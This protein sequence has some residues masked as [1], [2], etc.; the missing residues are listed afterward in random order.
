MNFI[1]TLYIHSNKDPFRDPFGWVSPEYHLMSWALSCLQLKQ[2]YKEVYLYANTPAA[3][4]LIDDLQ[5]PY[6]EVFCTHDKLILPHQELWALPKIYTYRLQ[7]KPFLHIDGDVFLFG[8]LP[9]SLLNNGLIAQNPEVATDY[10]T[11]TQKGLMNHFTFFPP[12]VKTDFEAP[13]PIRAVNAGI[14]GGQNISFINEY[15]NL[16]FEYV[17]KNIRYLQSINVNKFNVFFEQHLFYALAKEKNIPIG[18]LFSDLIDDNGYKHINDFHD[19]PFLRMYLHLLGHF[20][21]DEYTCIQMAA[22]LRELYPDYYY[23]IL[24]LFGKKE[25]TLSP[26]CFSKKIEVSVNYQ[27][28]HEKAQQAYND[29]IITIDNTSAAIDETTNTHLIRLKEVANFYSD[30]NEEMKKDFA[31]FYDSLIMILKKNL[32]FLYLYG[33]DLSAVSWYRH[34]FADETDLLERRIIKS[35][36]I[37]IISSQY[38]WEGLFNK[39]YRVGVEYYK[40]LQIQPGNYLSL[41]IPEA[42]ENSFSLYDINGLDKMILDFLSEPLSINELLSKMQVYF[43]D[44]VIQNHYQSYVD[45][46]VTCLKQLV[47]KKAI[48]PVHL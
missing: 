6:T 10:Y 12:C 24:S 40:Q 31:V 22:K 19:V 13:D 44:E 3:C 33:R 2:C 35:A 36:G 5:L 45:V 46:I 43:E 29:N 37:E 41:V 14:L 17:D 16:A 21:Q 32:S 9:E 47:L 48:Q 1:Q 25:I 34:L 38:E 15:A 4:L 27:A 39:H 26:C 18:F 11:S 8:R 30:G 20:K 7:E 42:S 23:K 28:L